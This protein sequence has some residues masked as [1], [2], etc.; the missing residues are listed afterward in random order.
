MYHV[1]AKPVKNKKMTVFLS[2]I[3]ET[4]IAANLLTKFRLKKSSKQWETLILSAEETWEA[5]HA[6]QRKGNESHA[7]G[8]KRAT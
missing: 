8:N 4:H 6:A 7:T 3:T 5:V 1:P 2:C